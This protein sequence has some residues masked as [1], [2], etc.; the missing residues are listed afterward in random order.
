MLFKRMRSAHL[1]QHD[2]LRKALHGLD[3]QTEQRLLVFGIV[4]LLL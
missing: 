2:E 1:Q 3:H 4:E